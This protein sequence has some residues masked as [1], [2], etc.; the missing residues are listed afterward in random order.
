MG[1][2]LVYDLHDQNDGYADNL[3]EHFLSDPKET[4]KLALD[5]VKAGHDNK[6]ALGYFPATM[7]EALTSA[8]D[9]AREETGI[10]EPTEVKKPISQDVELFT[11]SDIYSLNTPPRQ[12]I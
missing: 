6:T 4:A 10:Q 9:I 7:H 12:S 1:L 11:S 8:I 2:G 5:L 3:V